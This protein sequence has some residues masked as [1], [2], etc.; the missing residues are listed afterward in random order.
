MQNLASN[1]DETHVG[2]KATVS[3]S[4]F[5]FHQPMQSE[6]GSIKSPQFYEKKNIWQSERIYDTIYV[7]QNSR[8]NQTNLFLGLE[9]SKSTK[10]EGKTKPIYYEGENLL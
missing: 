9:E 10:N 2:P 3:T 6:L 5:T 8:T 4:N 1:Q 7:N